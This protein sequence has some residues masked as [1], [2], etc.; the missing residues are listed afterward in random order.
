[1]RLQ[2]QEQEQKE[3]LQ[4]EQEQGAAGAVQQEEA[5]AVQQ[6]QPGAVQVTHEAGSTSSTQV[7]AA[8]QE[9][10]QQT[11]GTQP[12]SHKSDTFNRVTSA[13][14]LSPS[15]G[16]ISPYKLHSHPDV[17]LCMRAVKWHAQRMGANLLAELVRLQLKSQLHERHG[18]LSAAQVGACCWSAGHLPI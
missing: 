12:Q 9:Q 4:R 17:L 7:P 13:T 14:S 10:P 6:G 1:V 11:P 3:Q 16:H 2:Q 18:L 5:G 8:A 15:P